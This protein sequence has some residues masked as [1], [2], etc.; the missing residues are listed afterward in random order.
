MLGEGPLGREPLL[1]EGLLQDSAPSVC[2]SISTKHVFI[3][4]VQRRAGGPRFVDG[5]VAEAVA[6]V[7]RDR[8][9]L[10]GYSGPNDRHET[11]AGAG[12]AGRG[13][14]RVAAVLAALAGTA[15]QRLPAA[16]VGGGVR[17]GQTGQLAIR[18]RH[19]ETTGLIKASKETSKPDLSE[20]GWRCGHTCD[21]LSSP[22]SAATRPCSPLE[23]T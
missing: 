8:K 13:A 9:H 3:Q 14:G 23:R 12:A 1:G 10:L 16:E 19:G 7:M 4:K 11:Q 6:M 20:E 5:G 2:S 15:L 17:R 22:L 18:L 21:R